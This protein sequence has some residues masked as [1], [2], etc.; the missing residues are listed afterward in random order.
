MRHPKGMSWTFFRTRLL[1]TLTAAGATVM[2]CGNSTGDDS[3]GSGGG[4]GSGTAGS[5]SGGS[6]GASAGNGGTGQGGSAGSSSGGSAGGGTAGSGTGGSGTLPDICLLPADPGECFA[7]IP[8]YFFNAETGQCEMFSYGGCGGNDNNFETL[9]ECRKACGRD[10]PPPLG[11]EVIDCKPGTRCVYIDVTPTCAAPCPDGGV[12][13]D[14]HQCTC[15][16]SCP[17]CDDCTMVCVGT[18]GAGNG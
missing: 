15:G 6:A 7:D 11:C 5:S 9:E 12:C 2:A 4:S 3:G 8:R 1:V 14:N 18:D 10:K 16:S 17:G 13:R